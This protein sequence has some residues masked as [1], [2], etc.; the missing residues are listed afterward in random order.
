[1]YSV[2]LPIKESPVL[3]KGKRISKARR[4]KYG[5]LTPSRSMIHPPRDGWIMTTGARAWMR[6]HVGAGAQSKRAF[7]NGKGAYFYDTKTWRNVMV[8]TFR[9]ANVAMLFK[10]AFGGS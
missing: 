10:L 1:M 7:Y 6:R 4:D 3:T 8:F 2:E 5:R 9:D